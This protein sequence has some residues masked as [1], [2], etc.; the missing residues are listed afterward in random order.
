M[1]FRVGEDRACPPLNLGTTTGDQEYH[2]S[3][4]PGRSP[5]MVGS[6]FWRILVGRHRWHE[7]NPDALHALAHWATDVAARHEKAPGVHV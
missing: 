1:P 7:L 2:E 6:G 3:A 5:V 4:W